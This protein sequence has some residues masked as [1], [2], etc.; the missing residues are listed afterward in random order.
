MQTKM[1][2]NG[3]KLL[4]AVMAFAMVLV[5]GF[6][7]INGSEGSDAI[8]TQTGVKALPENLT[9]G[10]KYY[11]AGTEENSTV[12]IESVSVAVTF[13]V[14]SGTTLTISAATATYA[15]YA[16]AASVEAPAED[17][18]I[19]ID[20]KSIAAVS[21]SASGASSYEVSATA[22]TTG[23]NG[24][25]SITTTSAS[26]PTLTGYAIK[27]TGVLENKSTYYTAGA[28]PTTGFAGPTSGTVTVDFVANATGVT[29]PLKAGSLSL[30]H[31]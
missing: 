28:I 25:G 18:T 6:V 17:G 9:A 1:N 27:V 3:V 23:T 22:T 15:V 29:V 13:L 10:E 31:I 16:V 19:D 11:V 8:E 21:A 4:T 2:K 12:T 7:V 26:G 24:E 14:K 5:A 30:I 20:A